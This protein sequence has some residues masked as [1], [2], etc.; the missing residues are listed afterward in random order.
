MG[1]DGPGSLSVY[2]C[3]MRC[4]VLTSR[5]VL[6]AY[7]HVLLDARYSH[8]VLC[9]RPTRVLCDGRVRGSLGRVEHGRDT[10]HPTHRYCGLGFGVRVQASGFKVQGLGVRVHSPGFTVHGSRFTVHGSR[11]TVHGSRFT[12]Q[13]NGRIDNERS[14]SRRRIGPCS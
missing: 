6:S 1:K 12:G 14:P 4:P 7:V 8:S 10:L 11:F 13:I 2:A 9:Y 5:T 3:A